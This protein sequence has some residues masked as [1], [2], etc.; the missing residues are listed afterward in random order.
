[1]FS[2]EFSSARFVSEADN[3]LVMCRIFQVPNLGMKLKQDSI[4]LSHT[5]RK[6]ITHPENNYFYLIEG[7]HRVRG[8]V[9]SEMRLR[10]LVCLVLPFPLRV[11]MIVLF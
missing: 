6:F 4:P 1:M 11:L 10:E 9:A 8:K 3:G 5:P 7:D 2:G